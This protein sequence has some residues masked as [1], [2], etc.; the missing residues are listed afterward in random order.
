MSSL[1]KVERII[2]YVF[3]AIGGA[4]GVVWVNLHKMDQLNPMY[5]IG[6]GIILGFIAARIVVNLLSR[7]Q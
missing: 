5:W 6:G 2:P 7:I 3:P 1:A 4:A